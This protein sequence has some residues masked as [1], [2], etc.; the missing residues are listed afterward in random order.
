VTLNATRYSNP[1]A[2]A[3]IDQARTSS[4]EH[5]ASSGYTELRQI[6]FDDALITFVHYKT[7]NYLM[8]KNVVGSSVNPTLEF[9]LQNVGFTG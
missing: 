6:V 9:R 2:D 5:S 1:E 3:L 4:N 7:I 8:Q